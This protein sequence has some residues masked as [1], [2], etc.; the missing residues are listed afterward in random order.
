MFVRLN[1]VCIFHFILVV[2]SI[3]MSANTAPDEFDRES[4]KIVLKE[5]RHDITTSDHVCTYFFRPWWSGYKIER[6]IA[7][8]KNRPK[9]PVQYSADYTKYPSENTDLPRPDVPVESFRGENFAPYKS[10]YREMHWGCFLACQDLRTM[11]EWVL[12]MMIMERRQARAVWSYSFLCAEGMVSMT[13]EEPSLRERESPE[14]I[15]DAFIFM[16][17]IKTKFRKADDELSLKG[18]DK[19]MIQKC[20]CFEATP[21]NEKMARWQI[22]VRGK[23]NSIASRANRQKR[24]LRPERSIANKRRKTEKNAESSNAPNE[25]NEG[26][27]EVDDLGPDWELERLDDE[28][29]QQTANMTCYDFDYPELD[30]PST[31]VA[32]AQQ[33]VEGVEGS[34]EFLQATLA[35]LTDFEVWQRTTDQSSGSRPPNKGHGT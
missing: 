18:D 33:D 9:T 4:D 32:V 31:E 27:W 26:D 16:D 30:V 24:G 2:Q 14:S 6:E 19:P 10:G 1:P 11:F 8:H 7:R 23:G 20:G 17:E 3:P 12:A 5:P 15:L 22:K 34:A 35:L 29:D 28:E 13:Y 21:E 25:R